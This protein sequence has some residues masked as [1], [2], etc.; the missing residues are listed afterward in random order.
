MSEQLVVDIVVG[1]VG[2]RVQSRVEVEPN[3]DPDL[4]QAHLLQTAVN[5]AQVLQ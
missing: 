1:V 5:P 2:H 4:A 3:L